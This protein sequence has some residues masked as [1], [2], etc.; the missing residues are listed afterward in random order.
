MIFLGADCLGLDEPALQK[1]ALAL[2][3]SDFVLGPASDGG[4]YLLGI[5]SLEPSVFHGINWGSPSV[6]KET[7]DRIRLLDKAVKLLEQRV[8]VDDWED[9]LSQRKFVDADLWQCL[10]LPDT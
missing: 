3:C 5:K 1:A 8:D 6:L 10:S 7:I 2:D 4:Y 9:L